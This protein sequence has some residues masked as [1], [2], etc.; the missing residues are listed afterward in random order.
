MINIK[1]S[2]WL[3]MTKNQHSVLCQPKSTAGVNSLEFIFFNL[4]RISFLFRPQSWRL[5]LRLK[6]VSS[7]KGKPSVRCRNTVRAEQAG[8][9]SWMTH[10]DGL[11]LTQVWQS[12]QGVFPPSAIKNAEQHFGTRVKVQPKFG[13]IMTM[14]G[15]RES[16]HRLPHKNTT[17]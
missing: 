3:L 6:E 2:C 13:Q 11:E 5:F 8:F 17:Q 9:S 14:N 1:V 4:T 16:A 15:K 10:V 12:Q 7:T